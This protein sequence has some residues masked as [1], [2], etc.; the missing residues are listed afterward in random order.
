MDKKIKQ[1]NIFSEVEI[2]I[3]TNSEEN[4]NAINELALNDKQR[5]EKKVLFNRTTGLIK[6]PDCMWKFVN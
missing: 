1:P 2:R 3:Q 4:L 5:N 6:H